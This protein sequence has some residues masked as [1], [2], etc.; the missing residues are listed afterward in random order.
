LAQRLARTLCKQCREPYAPSE[1]EASELAEAYGSAEFQDL[2]SK[3]YSLPLK[4]WRATGCNACSN[5]GYKGRIG[6]HVLLVTDDTLKHAIQKKASVDDIREL[7]R[8]SGMK[9]L[10]QDGIEKVLQ[11]HTDLKQVLAVCSR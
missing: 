6:I 8:L 1:R 7:A 3:H 9:T 2:V 4:L 10:L 5:S 11:G